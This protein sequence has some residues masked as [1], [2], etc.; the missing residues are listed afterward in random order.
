VKA[1][2][3]LV[4]M[5]LSLAAL[6]RGAEEGGAVGAA[7]RC[8]ERGE[9]G[10]GRGV[11][12]MALR[13]RSLATD[14]RAFVLDRLARFHEEMTGN[15]ERAKEFSRA[16]LKLATAADHPTR[17]RAEAR[18]AR[19][20]AGVRK[21]REEYSLLDAMRVETADP[22]ELTAR[23]ARLRGLIARNA[24]CP[25]LA[26]AHFYLG[27][28]L[29]AAGRHRPARRQYDRALELR[30]GLDFHLPVNSKL[31]RSRDT[32]VREFS[33]WAARAALGLLLAG[34]GAAFYLSRPWRRLGVRHVAAAGALA[35]AWW[36]FF[37][38]AARVCGGVAAGDG[39]GGGP[40]FVSGAPGSPGSEVLGVLFGYGLVAV[41]GSFVMAAGA[42]RLRLA[43]TRGAFG[44]AAAL[45]LAACLMTVFFLRHCD[46]AGRFE[47]HGDGPL[48]HVL[49]TV[50]L[51]VANIK[52]RALADPRSYPGLDLTNLDEAR[53]RR[54]IEEQYAV[55]EKGGAAG[56]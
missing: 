47:P 4:T 39:A 33:L 17:A 53:A 48:R 9:L 54:W 34:G 16:V 28:A 1:A 36:A 40:V 52:P 45:V 43:W 23:I 27:S 3:T 21:Y 22:D 7:E 11:L 19:L 29:A 2:A 46:R 56:R 42:S 38:V 10:E 6:A 12:V 14:E 50:R 20:A 31:K 18:F 25:R 30:P 49:G 35:A 13:D 51:P 41:A 15:F 24:E 55:I 8:F 26:E 37:S 44:A 5:L 32:W